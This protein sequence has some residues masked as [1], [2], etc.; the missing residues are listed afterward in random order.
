MKKNVEDFW[1]KCADRDIHGQIWD[2]QFFLAARRNLR[3]KA[4]VELADLSKPPYWVY[5]LLVEATF[6]AAPKQG[7]KKNMSPHAPFAKTLMHL[8]KHSSKVWTG[9]MAVRELN[10]KCLLTAEEEKAL[11]RKRPTGKQGQLAESL[12]FTEPMKSMAADWWKASIV[13][14]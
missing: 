7:K 9:V 3:H 8:V 11:I 2:T 6:W 5:Q 10:R 12:R 14:K 13:A 1:G 4:Y